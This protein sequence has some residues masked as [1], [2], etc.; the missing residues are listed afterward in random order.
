MARIAIYS[1]N[2]SDTVNLLKARMAE[3]GINMPKIKRTGSTFRGRVD[4]LII[5]YGASS[6]T[7]ATIGQA[8][9]LNSP[10]LIAGASN[11]LNAF[12]AFRTANVKTVPWTNSAEE[13]QAWLDDGKI[14]YARTTL[15]GHSGEGIKLAFN[16]P[17]TVGDAGD[18]EVTSNLPR[19]PLYTQAIMSERREYR[20]HVMKGR[21]TFVQQKKRRD[22]YRDLESFSML[23]RNH[24]TGWI[25]AAQQ[26]EPNDEAKR[27]AIKAIEALG[28]DYGAVDII[29]RRDEAWVLEVNTAPGMTGTNLETFA[30][31][32]KRIF[33]GGEPE[34]VM[35]A[36]A[37]TSLQEEIR[38]AEP[39][40]TRRP[41]QSGN[42][43]P[44]PAATAQ[45]VPTATPAP[46][47]VPQ[48]TQARAAQP[49]T[50]SALTAPVNNG[51]Y[52][53]TVSNERT[54]GKYNS[55]LA[56]FEI[57]GWEVPVEASEATVVE[58][59]CVL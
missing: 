49:R 26:A 41:R 17:A 42:T 37:L 27:E 46:A 6:L 59:L 45:P 2:V 31:N 58:Q 19:A 22:G 32:I 35:T 51:V 14:V 39:A 48:A 55:D 13:A 43:V 5:N 50:R 8:T 7:A 34:A 40:P 24:H 20:I 47:A 16:N 52:I 11:K 28:L 25:Y 10:E 12:Q 30:D 53:I 44:T 1:H 23:V 38:N 56:H 4:D 33:E 54:I 18:L 57:V 9:V 36:P 15:Q 21:I 3:L 29:T